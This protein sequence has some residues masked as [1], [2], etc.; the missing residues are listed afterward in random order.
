M[1][2][3]RERNGQFGSFRIHHSPQADLQMRLKEKEEELQFFKQHAER[4]KK[5]A[6]REKEEL[7]KQLEMVTKRNQEH[8]KQ[9]ES[10]K[11]EIERQKQNTITMQDVCMLYVH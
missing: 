2:I 5:E 11:R 4:I 8:K 1:Y 3:W 7:Q 10:V 9:L 6:E